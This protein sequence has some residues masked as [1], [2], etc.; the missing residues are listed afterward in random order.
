MVIRSSLLPAI[1]SPIAWSSCLSVTSAEMAREQSYAWALI[2]P[3]R[4]SSYVDEKSFGFRLARAL[5]S[6]ALA[7]KQAIAEHK[8][9]PPRLTPEGLVK[10]WGWKL[11]VPIE[12]LI[13]QARIRR[14][15]HASM[16]TIY[17]RS[18]R[19]KRPWRQCSVCGKLEIPPTARADKDTC[20]NK[21]RVRKHRAP[22]VELATIACGFCSWTWEGPASETERKYA[23]H[24]Q[25]F[26]SGLGNA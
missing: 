11:S 6:N 18:A 21:C 3:T 4:P 22:K 5:A 8:R 19:A 23:F 25:R 20:S 17:R 16:S 15:G 26:C 12:T 9:L 14:H 7:R 1:A 13:W 24:R 2:P 10:K